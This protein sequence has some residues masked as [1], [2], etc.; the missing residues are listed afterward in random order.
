MILGINNAIAIQSPAA[1]EF[2]RREREYLI[3]SQAARDVDYCQ[4]DLRDARE[5][6]GKSPLYTEDKLHE[7]QFA[8]KYAEL[9]YEHLARKHNRGEPITSSDVIFHTRRSN[10]PYSIQYY[11]EENLKLKRILKE[12]RRRYGSIP[13]LSIQL[14]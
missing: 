7:A 11:Y 5:N 10:Y 6:L 2:E 8:L 12:Y 3:L 4:R 1:D 13:D 14:K 9:N